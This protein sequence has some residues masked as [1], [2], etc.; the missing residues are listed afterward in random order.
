LFVDRTMLIDA[1]CAHRKLLVRDS[2]TL[3]DL[4]GVDFSL[5][6]SLD[7][8]RNIRSSPEVFGS[9]FFETFTTTTSDD[10]TVEL[11]PGGAQTDVTYESRAQY[12]DL[13]TSVSTARVT[14]LPLTRSL[15]PPYTAL[16]LACLHSTGCTSS[17]HKRPRSARAWAPSSPSRWW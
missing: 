5:V 17:T 1:H 13:V 3:A 15:N 6:K 11:L 7:L 12:C 9:T 14:P 10:R 2:P 4:E 16:P 8:L